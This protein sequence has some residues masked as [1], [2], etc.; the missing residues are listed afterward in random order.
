MGNSSSDVI[1]I[2]ENLSKRIISIRFILIA[3]IVFMHDN[4]TGVT[5]D[6]NL[7]PFT[8]DARY[9]PVPLYL[10]DIRL[11]I[12]KILGSAAVPLFFL[13]SGLLHYAKEHT[14]KDT[15]YKKSKTILLPYVLWNVIAVVFVY[16]FQNINFTESF[17]SNPQYQV[18]HY[19]IY[20]WVDVFLGKI[21]RN[22]RVPFVYQ[23][24]FLR[25][26]MILFIASPLIKI[27]IDKFPFFSLLLSFFLWFI[28][29]RLYILSAEA[30][31]FFMLGYY[32]VKYN[33]RIEKIDA[34]SFLEVSVFF[35]IL[36]ILQCSTKNS[37]VIE[38]TSIIVT[39]ILLIKLTSIFIQS[40]TVYRVLKQL[41]YYSFWV[42]AIHEPVLLTLIKN[43]SVKVIPMKGFFTV[44][45]Y[46]AVGFIT[47]FFALLSGII[48]KKIF[49][50]VYSVLTGNR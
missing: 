8:A 50:K 10:Y 48:I 35:V 28:N 23:F 43:I 22:P 34:I 42:Y 18:S 30:L 3:L 14:Y 13:I 31:F 33:L 47:I 25:D 19:S 39:M 17:F 49:P 1:G 32:V 38:K 40:T 37:V 11:F 27:V 41:A 16:L 24:W 20:Q 15:L 6:G 29:A 7:I 46:F 21:T 44:I 36:V 5:I 12:G 9:Y 4:L 2:D 45:Q 26:L